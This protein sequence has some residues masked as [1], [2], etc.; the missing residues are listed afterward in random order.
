VTTL[1]KG[2]P[3]EGA[4]VAI[5]D[6]RFRQIFT[7]RTDAQG[8]ARVNTPLAAQ[9]RDCLVDDGYFVSR[10]KAIASGP[11]QGVVDTSFVFSQWQKGIESWRFNLPT[12]FQPQAEVRG[13]TVFDRT[14]LRA[15]ETV[16]MKHFLRTETMQGLAFIDPAELPARVKVVHQG[17]GQE[18]TQPLQWNGQR[19]ARRRGRFPRPRSSGSTRFR[20]S[21]TFR[22]AR[23]PA[24]T[25]G[26]M[27]RSI[28]SGEV[29]RRRIPRAAR[30]CPPE[31][32]KG[33]QVAPRELPLNVQ[34]NYLAGGAMAGA[35]ATRLGACCATVRSPSRG[36][37]SSRSS[38]HAT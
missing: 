36:A 1:D 17:S 38:R 27:P 31:R 34:L 8:L 35:P 37:R 6:C 28:A 30:R 5:H 18:Y 23:L 24:D 10:R 21:A 22:P 19:S 26:R 9:P 13:H 7:G 14:L 11:A 4:D 29:P 12:D 32:P 16:S 15:G 2:K 20:S 3:V 25:A 33:A